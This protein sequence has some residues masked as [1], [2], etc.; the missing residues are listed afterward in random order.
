MITM[1]RL[2][3][4]DRFPRKIG[5]SPQIGRDVVKFR[6]TY[7]DNIYFGAGDIRARTVR[8]RGQ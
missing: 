7:G 3:I 8:N 2:R 1:L 6:W 5:P 4:I